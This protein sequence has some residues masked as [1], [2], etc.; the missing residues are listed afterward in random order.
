MNCLIQKGV[1]G[2]YLR[3]LISIYN[4]LC[5]CVKLGKGFRCNIGTRQGCKLS[6]ILFNLFIN[7]IIEELKRSG[8]QGIQISDDGSDILTILYA[9]DMANVSDT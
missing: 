2:I 9:D 3:L 5:S 7:E 4:N 8:I 1:H 6:P